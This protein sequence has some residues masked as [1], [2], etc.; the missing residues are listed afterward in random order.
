MQHIKTD[1]PKC[2]FVYSV[3]TGGYGKL[4]RDLRGSWGSGLPQ[5]NEYGTMCVFCG[6]RISL[7]P[8]MSSKGTGFPA[9]KSH[10]GR[11]GCRGCLCE[12]QTPLSQCTETSTGFVVVH[13]GGCA[14][15]GHCISSEIILHTPVPTCG[16]NWLFPVPLGAVT[17]P[18]DTVHSPVIP[19]GTWRC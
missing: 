13:P 8:P 16:G 18:R 1:V 4:Q 14:L 15:R 7:V 12:A 11:T 10:E 9:R 2:V 6:R 19:G 5:K 3:S 17:V